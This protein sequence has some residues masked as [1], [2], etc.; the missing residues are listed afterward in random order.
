MIGRRH[1]L[2]AGAAAPLLAAVPRQPAAAG[3]DQIAFNIIRH[4][5]VI[6][7]HVLDFTPQGDGMDI[8]IAVDI[9]VGLGPI[10][11]FRYRLQALEQW[12]GGATAY[13]EAAT[14]DDGT[15]TTMRAERDERGLW[16][17]ASRLERYLAPPDARLATHWNMAELNGPW[18]NPQDGRLLSPRVTPRGPERVPL[19]DGQAISADRYS[20]SG[21]ARLDLWYDEINRWAALSFEAHDGSTIRYERL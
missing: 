2:L 12:R 19:A 3:S 18:I 20:V 15:K 17:R 13:A 5:S 7:T 4:G 9:R 21:D 6:G 10:T 1:I 11:L 14:N 16:V 8:R